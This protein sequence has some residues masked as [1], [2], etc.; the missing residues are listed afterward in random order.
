MCYDHYT[1]RI[2]NQSENVYRGYN[3]LTGINFSFTNSLNFETKH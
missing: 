2:W 1:D 3:T